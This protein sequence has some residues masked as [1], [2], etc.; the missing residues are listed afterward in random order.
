[1]MMTLTIVSDNT[2]YCILNLYESIDM[3]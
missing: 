3:Y 2:I 1:M